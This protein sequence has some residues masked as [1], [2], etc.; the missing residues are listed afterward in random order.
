M[1][2]ADHLAAVVV[3]D[4]AQTVNN[5]HPATSNSTNNKHVSNQGD[6]RLRSGVVLGGM[7]VK[8]EEEGR[9]HSSKHNNLW[10][11]Q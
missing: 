3:N 7:G 9:N 6:Q 2:M 4:M 10:S 5:N 11:T 8:T 1:M